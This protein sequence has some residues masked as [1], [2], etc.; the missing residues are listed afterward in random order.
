MVSIM[1][2]LMSKLFSEKQLHQIPFFE[3][4]M[5]NAGEENTAS[6]RDNWY[7]IVPEEWILL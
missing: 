1:F 3:Q 6:L 4:M 2:K 7:I 5:C